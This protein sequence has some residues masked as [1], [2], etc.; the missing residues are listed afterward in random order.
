MLRTTPEYF[1]LIDRNSW[2]TMA[3]IEIKDIAGLSKPLKKLTEAIAE[4]IGGVSRPVFTPLN[5]NAKVYEIHTIADVC[6]KR[7]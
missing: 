1:Q 6:R 7:G 5:A 2:V 3:T 4:G